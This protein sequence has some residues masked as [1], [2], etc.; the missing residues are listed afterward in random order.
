[1]EEEE[2]YFAPFGMSQFDFNSMVRRRNLADLT[3]QLVEQGRVALPGVSAALS[4][5]NTAPPTDVEDDVA[6]TP[7]PLVPDESNIARR[8]SSF[9]CCG[10]SEDS[11]SF[12]TFFD[13]TCNRHTTTSEISSPMPT[14]S[15]P[16][17]Q[18]S[19]SCYSFSGFSWA[20]SSKA[21][22]VSSYNSGTAAP[23]PGYFSLQRRPAIRKKLRESVTKRLSLS[24]SLPATS[25]RAT[26]VSSYCSGTAAPKARYCPVRID[27]WFK[28]TSDMPGTEPLPLPASVGIAN[29][30][31]TSHHAPQQ[32]KS[33]E[34]ARE[35]VSQATTEP[36][37]GLPAAVTTLL[38]QCE[39]Q[40]E[41]QE[42]QPPVDRI[43]E[44]GR[45]RRAA[46]KLD[47]D[48]NDK[49]MLASDLISLVPMPSL[50]DSQETP[51]TDNGE[52]RKFFRERLARVVQRRIKFLRGELRVGDGRRIEHWY[53]DV[54]ELVGWRDE[55]ESRMSW[56]WRKKDGFF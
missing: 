8:S 5:N 3:Q 14:P 27:S 31:A 22:S 52:D 21:T 50:P 34:H 33:P 4:N 53:R 39:K 7:E 12:A 23:K 30:V 51:E 35:T 19:S 11:P 24:R 28:K 13:K 42:L 2:D 9:Y 38:Q 1:M 36:M 45:L 17:P 55:E 40:K 16:P 6:N 48:L 46:R 26:S 43:I 44:L 49:I 10:I 20:P 15:P 32:K 37:V 47:F 41:L 56:C 54:V 29:K 25:S 18:R